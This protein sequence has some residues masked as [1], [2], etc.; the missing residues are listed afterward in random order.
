MFLLDT[1]VLSEVLRPRPN[2]IVSRLLLTSDPAT[3]FASE[4]TRYELRMGARLRAD[5]EAFWARIEAR[6]V[7]LVQWLPIDSVVALAAADLAAGLRRAGS[8]LGWTDLMVG[9]TAQVHGLTMV[10]R[11]V[12]HFERI[13]DISIEN[14]FENE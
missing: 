3:R 6:L 7:P 14:W 1:N 8:P 10:T 13:A 4:I 12:R 9:A 11:N 5:A 2:L